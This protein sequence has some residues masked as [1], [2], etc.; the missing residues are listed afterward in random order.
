MTHGAC[1]EA[2]SHGG[3]KPLLPR[4]LLGQARPGPDQ[5]SE[6]HWSPLQRQTGG[7]FSGKTPPGAHF[8]PA[9]VLTLAMGKM[10][11]NTLKC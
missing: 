2:L 3:D 11:R 8:C 10:N 9:V 1:W 7:V 5:L 4:W 6:L